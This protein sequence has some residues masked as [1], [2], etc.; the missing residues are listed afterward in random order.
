MYYSAF[1]NLVGLF[2]IQFDRSP[3]AE[4]AFWARPRQNT[5]FAPFSSGK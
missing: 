3:Q 2:S 5:H 4:H 1:S